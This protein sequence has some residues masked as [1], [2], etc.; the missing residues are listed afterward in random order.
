MYRY[1]I[2]IIFYEDSKNTSYKNTNSTTGINKSYLLTVDHI[3]SISSVAQTSQ[4][5]V[6]RFKESMTYTDVV[7]KN[8]T[9]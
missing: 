6:G 7:P 4:M 3:T 8:K 1:K 9:I 5:R 2:R